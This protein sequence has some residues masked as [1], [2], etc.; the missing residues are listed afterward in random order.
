M[1]ELKDSR[2]IL[3]IAIGNDGR[4][5]DGLGWRF[6]DALEEYK[7]EIDIEYRYQLQVEDAD[8]LSGY[9]TVIFVDA[10]H[11]EL[12]GGYSFLKCLPTGTH[13]FTTH[14]LTPETVLWLAEELY[15]VHPEAYVLAIEGTDWELK[16]GL[17]NQAIENLEAA[18][19][20]FGAE[21]RSQF[22]SAFQ[23]ANP[24]YEEPE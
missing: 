18:L 14:T 13:T 3:L 15:D 19:E 8:L 5:D 6:A 12:P 16:Q 4:G 1:N 21:F 17:S 24:Q 11:G 23:Q 7:E 9:S 10:H 22:L 20:F 2:E